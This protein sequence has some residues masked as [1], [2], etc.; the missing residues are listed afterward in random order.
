MLLFGQVHAFNGRAAQ[1]L[2]DLQRAFPARAAQGV[3]QGDGRSLVH[4]LGLFFQ[5]AQVFSGNVIHFDKVRPGQELAYLDPDDP[6]GLKYDP[7]KS[8]PLLLAGERLDRLK[9]RPSF[10]DVE[11]NALLY[12]SGLVS[13]IRLLRVETESP[14][15]QP[16]QNGILAGIY[17]E[18]AAYLAYEPDAALGG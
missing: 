1:E 16:P 13:F 12:L 5:P 2:D 11:H 7:Y 18:V 3:Y 17:A 15:D 10:R 4:R 8:G 9:L 14:T 6:A